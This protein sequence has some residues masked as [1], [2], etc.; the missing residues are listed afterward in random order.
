MFGLRMSV[1]SRVYENDADILPKG[2]D[3]SSYPQ[4]SSTP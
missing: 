3:I 2:I 1:R 4:A